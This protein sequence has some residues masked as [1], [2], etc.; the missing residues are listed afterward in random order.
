MSNQ[1][2]KMSKLKRAFQM[3]AVSMPQRTICN[4]I[5]IGRG[6]LAKYKNA[7]DKEHLSYSD[8]GRMSEEDLH[9]FLKSTQV[10]AAPS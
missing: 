9:N 3:L 6:V 10:K 5:H 1:N 8:A 7:A 4:E 2:V